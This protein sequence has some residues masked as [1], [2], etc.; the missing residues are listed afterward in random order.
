MSDTAD[1]IGYLHS[2]QIIH[3][4][5]KPGNIMI[6]TDGHVKLIDFGLAVMSQS[7][8]RGCLRNGNPAVYAPDAIFV[9]TPIFVPIFTRSVRRFII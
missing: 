2:M 6:N 4:D 3:R 1:A 8:R 9:V 7:R 5:I